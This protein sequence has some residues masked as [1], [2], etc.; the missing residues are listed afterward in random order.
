VFEVGSG[1]L[2]TIKPLK[3]TVLLELPTLLIVRRTEMSFP[4]CSFVSKKV[5]EI[6]PAMAFPEA[7]H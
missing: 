6:A 2:A 3:V 4:I 7:I 1:A 5:S